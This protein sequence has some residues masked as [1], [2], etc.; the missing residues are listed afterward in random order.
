[1]FTSA[2]SLRSNRRRLAD[3][4]ECTI[5]V[6]EYLQIPGETAAPDSSIDCGMDDGMIY[7]IQASAYQKEVL[8]Q[9]LKHGEIASGA[10]RLSLGV[11]AFEDKNGLFLPP[12]LNIAANL[13]QGPHQDRRRLKAPLTGDK[14]I[15]VVKVSDSGGLARTESPAQIGD[16]VFGTLGDPVNLKSQL[17]DCSH[18]QMNVVPGT[19]P[20]ASVNEAAP[21]V[22]QH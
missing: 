7:N 5:L 1:M 21:G 16:D 19:I 17:Y 9:K 15:L 10:T 20:N 2:A 11:G 18:S 12:G 22:I 6:A 3:N 14:P 4:S 8:K 13:M